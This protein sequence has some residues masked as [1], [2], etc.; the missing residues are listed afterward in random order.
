MSSTSLQ[1][2]IIKLIGQETFSVLE[3]YTKDKPDMLHA[4]KLV[5]DDLS[6]FPDN[7]P[8]LENVLMAMVKVAV[9]S[10]TYRPT[11]IHDAC[12]TLIKSLGVDEAVREFMFSC[13]LDQGGLDGPSIRVFRNQV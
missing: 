5:F 11:A 12:K 8:V 13:L 3:A 1:A 9:Q 2:R 6:R 10:H 4:A 7:K